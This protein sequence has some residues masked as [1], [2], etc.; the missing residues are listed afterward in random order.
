ML[1]NQEVRVRSAPAPAA[2]RCTLLLFRHLQKTGG[3]SIRH[4]MHRLELSRDW[5]NYAEGTALYMEGSRRCSPRDAAEEESRLRM[6]APLA[7]GCNRSFVHPIALLKELAASCRAAAAA[8]T[9]TAPTD[10]TVATPTTA[11]ATVTVIT[12]TTAV[13]T[14]AV[15]ALSD[16][17]AQCV[18]RH[19]HDRAQQP[20]P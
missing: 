15:T 14:E 19:R 4:V 20:S 8:P 11:A 3:V 13:T 18:I 2:P 9:A 16:V 7:P 5:L 17:T 12:P 10:S 6:G 1:R